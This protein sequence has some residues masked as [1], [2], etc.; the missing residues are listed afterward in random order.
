[1]WHHDSPFIMVFVIS[2]TVCVFS[3]QKEESD[4]I[5]LFST[6]RRSKNGTERRKVIPERDGRNS[7]VTSSTCWQYCFRL[8]SQTTNIWKNRETHKTFL[9]HWAVLLDSPYYILGFIIF[10]IS[11]KTLSADRTNTWHLLVLSECQIGNHQET[12]KDLV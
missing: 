6:K 4:V 7:S 1:M 10:M 8:R 2:W 3:I 5:D 9:Y 11:E 12:M